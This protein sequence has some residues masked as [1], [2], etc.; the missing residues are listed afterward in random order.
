MTS[1]EFVED[2]LLPNIFI[3]VSC[4][5]FCLFIHFYP[6]RKYIHG[7]FDPLFYCVL[8]A[9]FA[10]TIPFFL[11]FT[12]SIRVE[13]F[14]YIVLVE[15][16]LWIGFLSSAKKKILFGEQV[17][18]DDVRISKYIFYLSLLILVV[19]KCISYYKTGIPLFMTSRLDAN[20]GGSGALDRLIRF[21]VIYCTIY[22]FY[23]HKRNNLFSYFV[24]V[25]IILFSILSGAKSEILIVAYSYFI[26]SFF[27]LGKNF[28]VK[29]KYL[30]FLLVT[31]L[32]VIMMQN[33]HSL[34]S[35]MGAM[36]FRFVA[37]GDCYWM[38]FPNGVIDDVEVN[39][40][41]KHF[42]SGL[43]GPL[44][45][46]PYDQ[47][48]QA[49]GVQLEWLVYPNLKG[50]TMGPNSRMPILAYVY[51]GWLGIF[52]AFL[53]GKFTSFLM[54]S[55]AS[56]LP[57]GLLCVSYVGYL[58]MASLSFLTDACLGVS[59]LFNILLTTFLFLFLLLLVNGRF[60]KV[61]LNG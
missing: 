38:A 41:V 54:Y 40:V 1:V 29:K 10:N 3:Y 44:R 34:F 26:Y 33:E 7:I 12:N 13:I 43:L 6:L 48:E 35:A 28:A 14:C 61:R 4:F 5:L 57:K 2:L 46:V 17:I 36:I 52:F 32:V 45:L 20:S 23:M 8:V 22:A 51:F 56:L 42:F 25:L 55:I 15:I 9:A 47:M 37:N 24:I 59:E 19:L 11:F 49:I 21:P 16:A 58:Y 60:L 39:D 18:V 27:Y 30:F 31:V 53:V 50:I